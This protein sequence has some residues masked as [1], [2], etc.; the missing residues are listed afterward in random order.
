MVNAHQWSATRRECSNWAKII[1]ISAILADLEIISHLEKPYANQKFQHVDVLNNMTHLPKNVPSVHLVHLLEILIK[2]KTE[3]AHHKNVTKM[4]KFN[5]EEIN[6]IDANHALKVQSLSVT[7]VQLHHHLLKNVIAAKHS[8]FG[9][10][11]VI[12]AEWEE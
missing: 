4:R 11:H 12:H 9:Q 1:A 5:L 8:M 2:F 3:F 7:H 10:T 6:A